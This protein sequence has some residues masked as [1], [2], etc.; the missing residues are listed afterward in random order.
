MTLGSSVG[1]D[2]DIDPITGTDHD[3][4]VAVTI[5]D[6][7]HIVGLELDHNWRVDIG[8]A[9]LEQSFV[10]AYGAAMAELS[11]V[12]LA[13]SAQMFEAFEENLVGADDAR[14][15]S[16]PT[17]MSEDE[18]HEA[19]TTLRES[20]AERTG[21]AERLTQVK[22]E[23]RRHTTT[24]GRLTVE[25]RDGLPLALHVHDRW[26]EGRDATWCARALYG[27]IETA[28]AAQ[29]AA[30]HQLAVEFPATFRLLELSQNRTR[31][32]DLGR[33]TTHDEEDPS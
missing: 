2:A 6:G 14:P 31:S 29:E 11:D 7:G 19:L 4:Y 8:P 24:D 22:T 9:G 10:E 5:A 20:G 12:V 15:G 27:L 33:T 21:Y 32:A 1:V 28:R 3:Q 23:I 30:M 26:G 16:L 13:R 18:R 25:T 17:P